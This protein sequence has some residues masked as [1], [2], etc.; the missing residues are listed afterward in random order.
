MAQFVGVCVSVYLGFRHGAP[1]L[2]AYASVPGFKSTLRCMWA[3][4]C[5]Q[6]YG[7]ANTSLKRWILGFA[8]RRKEAELMRGIV[9][10]DSIW[11]KL[12]FR[13]VQ[14]GGC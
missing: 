2:C 1:D 6:I 4:V 3:L 5:V 9:R 13:K 8:Y 10:R 12:I 11:D 7:Q 14:V